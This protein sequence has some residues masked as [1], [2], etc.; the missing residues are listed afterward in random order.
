MKVLIFLLSGILPIHSYAGVF[1]C[2]NADGKTNYQAT[3]CDV[4]HQNLELNIKTGS[5]VDLDEK[6][7]KAFLDQ[8]LQEKEQAKVELDQKQQQLRL[9][10]LKTNSAKESE[11]NQLLIKNNPQ[12]FS[13]FAIPPYEFDNLSS[14]VKTYQD[15]LP[16]IERLRRV[17][18]Q[19]AL[20]TGQCVR[21]EA[22]ELNIKTTKNALVFLVDCSTAKKFYFSEQELSN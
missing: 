7:K 5:S 6:Q 22:V 21:V 10:E 11:A 1:K 4:G 19:K 13:A 15:K 20:A 14:F 8:Q 9:E 16:D 2:T 12:Q 17:S 3:P 18:A